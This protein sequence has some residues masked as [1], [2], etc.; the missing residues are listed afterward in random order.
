MS[1]TGSLIHSNT[2]LCQGLLKSPGI[3]EKI[4]VA[5]QSSSV[6]LTEATAVLYAWNAE[7]P[8]MGRGEA[9][10]GVEAGA[11]QE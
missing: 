3:W 6:W 10:C 2:V 9:G 7:T 11:C 5:P 1:D 8:G 4:P